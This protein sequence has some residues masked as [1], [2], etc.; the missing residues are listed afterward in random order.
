M[1][2]GKRS[3][4]SS[5]A[6]AVATEPEVDPEHVPPVVSSYI[7]RD[8]RVYEASL[9]WVIRP[10]KR[11]LGLDLGTNCGVAF[12]DLIPG[13][14]I[15]APHIVGGI[16]DLS[17]GPYDSGPLRHLRL[18]QFLAVAKP[19]V[20]MFEEV[21]YDPPAELI[22][23]RN[24]NAGA[25]VARVATA[26]EFLGGLKVTVATWCEEHNIPA[27]GLGIA[28]IKKFATGKGNAGKPDMIRAC[29]ERYGTTLNPEDYAR[30]GDD[31]IADAIF[32]CGIGLQEYSEGL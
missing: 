20:V 21:K 12:C 32:V 28:K 24:M 2:S 31:N 14:P 30:S 22:K 8:P 26:A 19:D 25:I 29:N 27:H 16:W 23:A 5:Q 9:P 10:M 7:T 6:E 11:I 18:K 15:L 4:G 3:Q 17:L 13:Q 1:A